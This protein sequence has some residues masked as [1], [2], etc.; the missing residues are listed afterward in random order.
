MENRIKEL[1]MQVTSLQEQV[2]AL[3]ID[4]M[5]L[6]KQ[7]DNNAAWIQQEEKSKILL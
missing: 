2:K 4:V 7:I 6:Q 1:E 5:Y 3:Q